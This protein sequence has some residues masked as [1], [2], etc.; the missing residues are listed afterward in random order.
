MTDLLDA[1]GDISR[2][3]REL[4]RGRMERWTEGN[5]GGRQIV[6]L[7]TVAVNAAPGPPRWLRPLWNRT[8][9]QV[10]L[11][12]W[13]GGLWHRLVNA[14]R[15]CIEGRFNCVIHRLRKSLVSDGNVLLFLYLLQ[16][17]FLVDN[18]INDV[19]IFRNLLGHFFHSYVL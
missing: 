2:K 8:C 13:R 12:I 3:I 15:L 10:L 7:L 1:L 6:L 16:R 14:L 9:R 19:A 4:F 5:V 17:L 11:F 18:R